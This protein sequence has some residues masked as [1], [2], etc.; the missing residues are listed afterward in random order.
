[1]AGVETVEG[2]LIKIAG[3]QKYDKAEKQRFYSSLVAIAER[4]GRAKGW[5]SHTYRDKFGTWPRN[6]DWYAD[7][8]DQDVA[9]FVRAKAIAYAKRQ[10]SAPH[11]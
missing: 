2:E 7:G 8:P 4:R 11:A 9:N 10:G 6:L 1:M 5:V 3:N